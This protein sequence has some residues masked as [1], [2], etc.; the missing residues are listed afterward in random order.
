MPISTV[1]GQSASLL[2]GKSIRAP[3]LF[4]RRA[5]ASLSKPRGE[6]RIRGYASL[7]GVLDLGRDVV[8]PGAF[9]ESIARRGAE[10]IRLLWQHQPSEP[11]G[12]WTRIE[13]DRRGLI[14]EGEL[15]LALPKAR[16]LFALI[17]RGGLDGLS[18]GY[19][20]ESERRDPATGI[21]NLEKIDLWEISLVSFPLLPQARLH[22]VKSGTQGANGA[23]ISRPAPTCRIA[24][25]C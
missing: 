21:R 14:V 22:D 25:S 5:D 11:V 6:G 15:D 16:D 23:A 10:G 20:S 24:A 17:Q 3:G 13:E 9:R 4:S 2:A 1:S 8:L 18:I 19:R 12:R 7:F